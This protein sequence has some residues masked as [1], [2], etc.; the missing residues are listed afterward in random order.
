MAM[1]RIPKPETPY[2]AYLDA[3]KL[4][5]EL[6]IR[7][8]RE[9]DHFYPLGMSGKKLL[10]DFMIDAKIPLNLKSSILILCSGD[11][12]AWIIGYRIDDKFKLTNSTKRVLKLTYLPHDQ[13]I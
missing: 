2:L 3:N 1:N 7:T 12:I 13:S 5:K 11:N 10:S 8:R 9:G 6:K 4:R